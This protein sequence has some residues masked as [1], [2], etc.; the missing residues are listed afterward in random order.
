MKIKRTLI[1]KIVCSNCSKPLGTIINGTVYPFLLPMGSYNGDTICRMSVYD[2]DE[3][4]D[5]YCQNCYLEGD[6]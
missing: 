6:V 1:C 5:M 3:G 4:V 2:D